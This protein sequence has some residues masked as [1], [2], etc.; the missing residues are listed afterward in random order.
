MFSR[1]FI[2]RPVFSWV[3]AIIIMLAG[4]LSI[5]TLPGESVSSDR[6]SSSEHHRDL[7]WC[8]CEHD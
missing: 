2:D 4:I 1:F 5:S 7:S 8:I 6:S 3:I